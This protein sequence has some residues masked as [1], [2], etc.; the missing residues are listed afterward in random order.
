[1]ILP[2]KVHFNPNPLRIIQ[3]TNTIHVIITCTNWVFD[4]YSFSSKSCFHVRSGKA[5]PSNFKNCLTLFPQVYSTEI[6]KSNKCFMSKNLLHVCLLNIVIV[7]NP[8]KTYN[9]LTTIKLH[10]INWA[11]WWENLFMPYANNKGADQP[12]H[13][14]SPISAFVFA[15]WIVQY[16]YLL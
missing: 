4:Y 5:V 16:L 11:A 12:A 9:M 3:H 15:A 14:R 8:F 10:Y 7:C 13:P 6:Q 1:M 2:I